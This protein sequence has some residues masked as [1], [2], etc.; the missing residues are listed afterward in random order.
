MSR[1]FGLISAAVV[2]LTGVTSAHAQT[3][4]SYGIDDL[5]YG[6]VAS[7]Y[8]PFG[9]FGLEYSQ[10][11]RAGAVM[12][13]R[14][15]MPY[16]APIVAQSPASSV[17]PARLAQTRDR[18]SRSSAQPVYQLTTGSLYWPA[19]SGAI[20]Y[21]PAMRYQSYGYGYGTGP[22]GGIDSGIMWMGWPLSY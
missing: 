15:G 12:L 21:S 13:D 1:T 18:S 4:D 11:P 6:A 8:R 5:G 17:P 19:G 7:E 22:A 10:V 14:A 20:P 9:G 3:P 16:R 2:L